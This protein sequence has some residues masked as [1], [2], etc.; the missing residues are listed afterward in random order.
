M[1]DDGDRGLEHLALPVGR[2]AAGDGRAHHV[3][4][5]A[6]HRPVHVGMDHVPG[7]QRPRPVPG[8]HALPQE[9]VRA[10]TGNHGDVERERPL[11]HALLQ[12]GEHA[13][14]LGGAGLGGLH[15]GGHHLAAHARR[16]A[17][18][19]DLGRRLDAPHRLDEIVRPREAHA[20]QCFADAVDGDVRQALAADQADVR[21]AEP[22][23][24]ERLREPGP[25]VERHLHVGDL[26]EVLAPVGDLD[27]ERAV[28]ARRHDE[29][30]VAAAGPL[31]GPVRDLRER[32]VVIG[33]VE[34]VR[35]PV[36]AVGA[37]AD[38][39]H[40]VEP[41]LGRGRAQALPALGVLRARHA[42]GNT[43][44]V[45]C[46]TH[47]NAPCVIASAHHELVVGPVAR[48]V[49]EAA[50]DAARV[51]VAPGVDASVR[52]IRVA[53]RDSWTWPCRLTSGW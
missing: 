4:E 33:E 12:R 3:V 18:E 7:L 43:D 8:R 29:A 48:E 13:V 36:G 1:L 44:L 53:P 40:A 23:P 25:E 19:V 16:L 35:A 49:D 52:P 41:A 38:D 17:D 6:V 47:C 22:A 34:D 45:G 37:A 21:V 11:R 51:V 50:G 32:R 9:V 28:L 2:L 30:G 10:L 31:A 27:D 5:V 15:E 42:A 24:L 14:G 46:G 26:H 20:R 39:Q